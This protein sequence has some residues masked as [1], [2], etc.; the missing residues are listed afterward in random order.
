M[1]FLENGS[2]LV[3]RFLNILKLTTQLDEGGF[4]RN[5]V[6]RDLKNSTNGIEDAKSSYKILQINNITISMMY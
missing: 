2:H 5:R 4:T 6:C 3:T 1:Q